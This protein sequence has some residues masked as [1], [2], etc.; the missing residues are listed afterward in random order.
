MNK[1]YERHEKF[2][3]L[4]QNRAMMQSE[5]RAMLIVSLIEKSRVFV[6]KT[7]GDRA[8]ASFPNPQRQMHLVLGDVTCVQLRAVIPQGR[9][10]LLSHRVDLS[11]ARDNSPVRYTAQS[12]VVPTELNRRQSCETRHH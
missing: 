12:D 3:V 4:E 10:Q 11:P 9:S 2:L 5:Q 7:A 1:V 8:Q 6:L